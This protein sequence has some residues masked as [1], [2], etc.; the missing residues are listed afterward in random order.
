LVK[1]IFSKKKQSVWVVTTGR[2]QTGKTNFTLR[3]MEILHEENLAHGFG[4]NVESL[5]APFDVDFINDYQTLKQKC[6]MLN[7]DPERHGIKRYFYFGS[8]MGKF[9]PRDQPHRNVKFIEELQLVRKIGLN[10]LGDGINRIDRRVINATHF[11]GEFVK[12]SISRPDL[13]L[14]RNYQTQ[15]QI[16]IEGIRPTSLKYNTWESC[17][18]YMEPQTDD[19]DIP[20]NQDHLIVKKYLDAGCSIAKT[21]LHSQEVKRARD[22]VLRYYWT[23][24][25]QPQTEEK[26]ASVEESGID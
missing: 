17:N 25:L 6:Q 7:P 3:L 1:K 15:Q 11:D 12:V 5:K 23:H 13:A 24:H 22:R 21:G 10:W 19:T 16:T 2:K 26:E 20:L 18:F 4:S 14:Y 9:L 8:E